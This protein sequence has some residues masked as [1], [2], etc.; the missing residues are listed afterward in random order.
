VEESFCG[1]G[2]GVGM[3][4]P[5]PALGLAAEDCGMG[6]G[7]VELR[8]QAAGSRQRTAS[9]GS[10]RGTKEEEGRRSITTQSKG[11]LMGM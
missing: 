1:W 10:A 7:G 9:R 11:F 5:V 6:A 4:L 8:W 3:G 2:G